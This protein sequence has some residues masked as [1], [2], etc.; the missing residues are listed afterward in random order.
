MFVP[1]CV[2]EFLGQAANGGLNVLSI[3]VLLAFRKSVMQGCCTAPSSENERILRPVMIE[4]YLAV[5]DESFKSNGSS[6]TS[7]LDCGMKT[8]I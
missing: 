4:G 5:F 1:I 8:K 2:N 7:P 3:G 6:A